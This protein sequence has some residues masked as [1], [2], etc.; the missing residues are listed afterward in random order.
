MD[1]MSVEYFMCGY[2]GQPTSKEG[3]PLT[4]EEINSDK[5]PDGWDNA[6]WVHGLCCAGQQQHAQDSRTITREMAMDAGD[7]NLEGQP[8]YK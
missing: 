1:A 8:L 5:Y 4:L 6:E 2:C 3:E 7:I